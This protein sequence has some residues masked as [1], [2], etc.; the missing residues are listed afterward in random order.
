MRLFDTLISR[1]LPAMPRS[2]V[3]WVANQYIAGETSA[4]ALLKIRELNGIGATATLDLLGEEI[5]DPELSRG[6]AR[7]SEGLLASIAKD[8]LGAGVSVK[9]SAFMLMES[10]DLALELTREIVTKARD[11]GRFVRIDMEDST[12]TDATLDVCRAL[13]SEGLGNFGVVLQACLRR[14]YADAAALAD[15]GVDVRLVKGI[16]IEAEKIAYRDPEAVRRNYVRILRLL[17]EKGCTVCSATHDD[18]LI[19][20]TE[21]AMADFGISPGG[22]EFQMLLGVRENARDALL[23]NGHRVRIYVPFGELW[24][25]YSVRRLHENPAIAGHVTKQLMGRVFSRGKR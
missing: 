24:Y 6:I 2:L 7:R 5:H 4:D 15:L 23:A 1:T 17:L 19:Y 21:A 16:Y 8:D 25:E 20:E 11:A 22:L 12:T 10:P 3:R 9:L 18:V 13:R 14:T